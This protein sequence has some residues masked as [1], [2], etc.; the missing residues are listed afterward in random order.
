[1]VSNASLKW[2]VG[3][4]ALMLVATT[5]G[6]APTT[7]LGVTRKKINSAAIT[8][9]DG[10]LSSKNA[11]QS[12]YH[13]VPAIRHRTKLN[14]S[15]NNEGPP[16]PIA[17]FISLVLLFFIVSAVAPL[18]EFAS[19]TPTDL[20][21]GD[22][23]VTRQDEATKLKNYQSSFDALKPAKIQEKLSNL[24]VF[25][26]V[27]GDASIGNNFYL[28]FSEADSAAKSSGG[29]VKV[30]TSD[31]IVYPLILK[32][33]AEVKTTKPAPAEIKAATESIESGKYNL[34]PS[35]AALNDA[36]GL[37]LK[38]GDIPLFVVERL[39]F[40][41]NDGRPQVPLFTEKNDA[42]VSYSRLRESGGNKL[43][44]EPTIRPTSL[45]DVLNSM[46]KGTRPAVSQ[47]VFYGN[48][49]DVLKADEMMSP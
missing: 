47:L 31:K 28:S 34:V 13:Q 32:R 24:P 7:V 36:K 40:A 18:V 10:A 33:G 41:G 6:F 29:S 46:E 12:N 42:I 38:E 30:T 16:L 11:L 20:S 35:N 44:E 3:I 39:A 19:N 21:L 25:Y 27:N 43:P 8:K 26:T 22:A 48:S 17:A 1:M 23:V 49:D 15:D 45:M 9:H 14:M 5:E 4:L 37:T 2:A